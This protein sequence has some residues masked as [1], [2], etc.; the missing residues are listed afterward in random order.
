MWNTGTQLS[1]QRRSNLLPK[2]LGELLGTDRFVAVLQ[3]VENPL[4]R[5]GNALAGVIALCGHH[6]DRL[7]KDRGG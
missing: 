2:G 5:Q 7:G 1:R 4:Q 3:F 6:V